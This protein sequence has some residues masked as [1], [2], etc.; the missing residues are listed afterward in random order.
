VKAAHTLS[1]VCS[2][3]AQEV[4]LGRAQK[5]ETALLDHRGLSI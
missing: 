3:L 2:V 5:G 4:P 1:G